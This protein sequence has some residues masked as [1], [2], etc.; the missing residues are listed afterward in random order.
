[1]NNLTNFNR[2]LELCI[3]LINDWCEELPQDEDLEES[4]IEDAVANLSEDF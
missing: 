1:M 3:E 2:A 4:H